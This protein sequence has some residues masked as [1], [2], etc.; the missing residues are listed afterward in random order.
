MLAEKLRIAMLSAHSC[1]VGKL[2]A[3]DTGGMSVYI[4]EL[5][6]ELGKLGHSVD[7]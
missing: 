6:R 1:P 4:R 7:I 3:R 5:S 2:G